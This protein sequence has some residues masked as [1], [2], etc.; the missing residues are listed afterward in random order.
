MSNQGP[1]ITTNLYRSQRGQAIVLC[2]EKER[3]GCV[4][5]AVK[6]WGISFPCV[7]SQSGI[8]TSNSTVLET[9]YEHTSQHIEITVLKP[10]NKLKIIFQNI[11]NRFIL[12][13][14]YH[15]N[16]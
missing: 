2:V 10:L 5:V 9:K 7:P 16:K 1:Y 13:I 8:A 15:V 6:I 12:Q 3:A 4:S 14:K 11:R